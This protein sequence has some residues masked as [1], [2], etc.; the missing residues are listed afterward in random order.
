MIAVED[1]ANEPA[2]SGSPIDTQCQ[3]LVD[4][5]IHRAAGVC[6]EHMVGLA[7]LP[8][9]QALLKHLLSFIYWE[10]ILT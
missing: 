4:D 2:P 7:L 8:C 10:H 1:M 6:P 3:H 5:A 9:M